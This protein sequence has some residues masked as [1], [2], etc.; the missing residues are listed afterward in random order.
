MRRTY[1]IGIAVLVGVA[2]VAAVLFREREPEYQGRTLSSWLQQGTEPPRHVKKIAEAHAAIQAMGAEQVVPV[3]LR[4]VR[5]SD[6]QR[7]VRSLMLDLAHQ[8][9]IYIGPIYQSDDPSDMASA[10]FQAL[11][12]NAAFAVPAL[13]EI[14]NQPSHTMTAFR[15]LSHIGSPARQVIT[16]ALT[17]NDARIR[18][19]AVSSLTEVVDQPDQAV[20]LVKDRLTDTDAEVRTS[21]IQVL[22]TRLRTEPNSLPLL[23]EVVR[24]GDTNDATVAAT[25]LANFTTNAIS[26]FETLSN[27][28][29]QSPHTY[30]ALTS[31]RSMLQIAP[32][33]TLPILSRRLH[34]IDPWLRSQSLMLLVREYPKPEDVI[35][36]VEYA[37]QD[38]EEFIA[39]RADGFL[40]RFKQPQPSTIVNPK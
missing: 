34:S 26:A 18:S 8:F 38:P 15:C 13:A 2:I 7:S 24:R 12:T 30:L 40:E 5:S 31:L 20:N 1:W 9:N 4:L 22:G 29:Y 37:A 14:A 36:A 21:A 19:F 6:R 39:T 25:E 35:P 28:A 27:A 10:G 33:R 16:Q 11:G 3:L 23:I 32:E 17:N